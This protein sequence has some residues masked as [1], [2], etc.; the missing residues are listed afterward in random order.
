MTAAPKNIL[1]V[2]LDNV[3]DAV[4]ASAVLQPLKRLFPESRV[5]LWVKQYAAGLF[6][7]H[8]L[9]DVVHAS[10][11]F[12][13]SAPGV[14]KGRFG[15]FMRTL[16][17]IRRARYDTALVL[18]AEWR[19][20]FA[21]VWAGIPSRVG[22]R[23]RWS[24]PFLTVAI[25]GPAEGQ[26]FVDDHRALV[27]QW[28]G[29]SVSREDSLPRLETTAEEERWWASWSVAHGLSDRGFTMLHLFSG[30]EDKNWP[31]SCW[32]EL[33]E[34][35]REKDPGE[36]FVAL[37]GPGEEDKLAL[38]KSRLARTGAVLLS[39]PT[40]SQLKAALRHARLLVGGDSG[41]GHV[42]AALKTPTLS[43]F[44]PTRPSRS[45]PLG[46]GA[47]DVV[48]ASPLRNLLVPEV[49]AAMKK[50]SLVYNSAS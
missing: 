44:G 39:A 41:P 33:I 50:F 17:D 18:N 48:T 16:A 38:F 47:L 15:A 20:S 1:V 14:A 32:V 43:L 21:C 26:H 37:C 34:R 25:A 9:I 19:R 12:W 8:P 30:D 2:A 23:R 35:W 10:D 40:L 22:Y 28:T 24:A 7:D 49:L 42:A 4:M 36:R 29:R 13:D 3:G 5:G 6:A 46:R 31:L 45:R 11:P 27:E